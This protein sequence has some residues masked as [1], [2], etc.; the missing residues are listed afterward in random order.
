MIK[1]LARLRQQG[2]SA[3]M[4]FWGNKGTEECN[5]LIERERLQDV[6][7]ITGY[8]E[9]EEYLAGLELS[10]IIL[11]LRYPT[12]GESSATL[13]ETMKAGKPSLVTAINQYLEFPNDV[14]WKVPLGRMEVPALTAM[15]QYLLEHE[16]VREAMAENARAYADR[17]LNGDNIAGLYARML[18]DE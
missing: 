4:V 8:L 13:C 12:M 1:S 18:R 9:R 11:N 2:Y 14:C 6:V 5:A 17:I 3:K 16:E 10:D 7:I 15:L